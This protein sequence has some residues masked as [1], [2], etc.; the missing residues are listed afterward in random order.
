MLF[1]LPEHPQMMAEV[2]VSHVLREAALHKVRVGQTLCRA[3]PENSLCVQRGDFAHPAPHISQGR[4]MGQG[5][6]LAAHSGEKAVL[7]PEEGTAEVT[8]QLSGTGKS[9]LPRCCSVNRV[10]LGR[11]TAIL[12]KSQ[13]YLDKQLGKCWSEESW[14]SCFHQLSAAPSLDFWLC[15][16][17][18]LFQQA[19]GWHLNIWSGLSCSDPRVSPASWCW[20]KPVNFGW[21]ITQCHFVLWLSLDRKSLS[22]HWRVS[23]PHLWLDA[24]ALLVKMRTGAFTP[25]TVCYL[26]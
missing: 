18:W 14:G 21:L 7:A 17:P 26:S 9:L 11:I 5:P 23:T 1:V 16:F 4:W 20:R 2:A 13:H 10:T 8:C 15:I 3:A 12:L 24:T 6:C 22:R 25:W 19:A